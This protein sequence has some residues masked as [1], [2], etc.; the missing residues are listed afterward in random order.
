MTTQKYAAG[1]KVS[2]STSQA[3]ILRLLAKHGASDCGIAT[4]ADAL[5][6]AFVIKG[7]KVRLRF[8]LPTHADK[9]EPWSITVS[10]YVNGTWRACLFDPAT[11]ANRVTPKL[12]G[13]LEQGV[14]ERW[15]LVVLAVKTKLEI[16]AL[17]ARTIEQE[18][19]DGL[20]LPNGNTVAAELAAVFNL[21]PGPLALP[22]GPVAPSA[23]TGVG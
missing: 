10:K 19:L 11:D 18:F 7:C 8:P 12:A 5:M 15:R 1:T 23:G 16:V 21:P 17:G 9:G 13:K 20:V 14:R 22:P 3:E 2:V 4:Q 6:L